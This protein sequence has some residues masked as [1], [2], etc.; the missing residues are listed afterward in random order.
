MLPN[1]YTRR[2]VNLV[3]INMPLKRTTLETFAGLAKAIDW[4]DVSLQ[5]IL[6]NLGM[7]S[8]NRTQSMILIHISNGVTR[9]SEIAREMG[10]TR[11]NIHSMAKHLIDNH[12]V[13]LISDP[14]D[15]TSKQYAFSDDSQELRDTVLKGARSARQ[16][17][18]DRIGKDTMQELNRALSAD[19]G[20][21]VKEIPPGTA[22][23]R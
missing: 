17:L 10:T 16:K 23:I 14:N 19:W 15:R 2:S 5:S 6:K 21:P 12:I 8:V 1:C 13:K 7:T 3:A 20:E 18:A 4:Y 9:P 22:K 11:Q